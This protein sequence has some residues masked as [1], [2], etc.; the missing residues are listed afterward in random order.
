MNDEQLRG[1]LGL[2]A[3]RVPPR[4]DAPARVRALARRQRRRHYA[5]GFAA[6]TVLV[7]AAV[8]VP[9]VLAQRSGPHIQAAPGPTPTPTISPT[10][11]MTT[12]CTPALTK[13]VSVYGTIQHFYGVRTS[14]D[15]AN[16]FSQNLTFTG[17]PVDFCLAVGNLDNL[18]ASSPPG[19]TPQQMH[20]AVMAAN[21]VGEPVLVYASA[22]RPTTS[23]LPGISP[24]AI[25][26]YRPSGGPSTTQSGS[27]PANTTGLTTTCT[28]ALTKAADD[29]GNIQHLYGL[30]TS[31]ADAAAFAQNLQVTGAFVDFCLVVGDLNQLHPPGPPGAPDQM[32]YALLAANSDAVPV[33]VYSSA[34]RPTSPLPGISSNAIAAYRSG[35]APSP[36]THPSTTRS[37]AAAA[38][39]ATPCGALP[40]SDG[41]G[42]SQVA[43][44]IEAPARATAGTT[45]SLRVFMH[46][47]TGS[48]ESFQTG[49]PFDVFVTKAGSVVARFGGPY[50]G[51]GLGMTVPATGRTELPPGYASVTLTGCA[52]TSPR[53]S[54]IVA[55]QPLPAG[56]YQ[57]AVVLPDD[58]GSKLLTRQHAHVNHCD[59]E[60]AD[61]SAPRLRPPIAERRPAHRGSPPPVRLGPSRKDPA[62]DESPSEMAIPAATALAPGTVRLTRQPPTAVRPTGHNG[63]ELRAC[64]ASGQRPA[65]R[66]GRRRSHL[67]VDRAGPLP[68]GPHRHRPPTQ[69]LAEAATRA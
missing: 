7:V 42:R 63:W 9:A 32:H 69:A 56:E 23:P 49:T 19:S 14:A 36:T 12:T 27:A 4:P 59:P 18:S 66:L 5:G 1:R 40:T 20:Y 22:D 55:G 51:T 60:L 30:R 68:P 65:H 17:G 62:S 11:A 21:S 67:G 24:A 8:A 58:Q 43:A 48:A 2:L 10:T 15:R 37:A 53:P 29:Y 54:G 45:L 38:A 52:G 28:P 6:L 16:A 46:S 34:D 64:W 35:L 61:V 39:N 31:A 3:E 25:D 41:P 26:S 13:A 50:V 44:T 57:V 33:L 47:L